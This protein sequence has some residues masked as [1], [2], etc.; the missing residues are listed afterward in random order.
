MGTESSDPAATTASGFPRAEARRA[1][2]KN[3]SNLV[4]FVYFASE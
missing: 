2:E 1:S 4:Q 3:G